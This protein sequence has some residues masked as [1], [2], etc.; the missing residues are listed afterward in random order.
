MPPLGHRAGAQKSPRKRGT[1]QRQHRFRSQ[2]CR[3]GAA[4]SRASDAAQWN[5]EAHSQRVRATRVPGHHGLHRAGASR[6]RPGGGPHRQ[7]HA[8]VGSAASAGEGHLLCLDCA[9]G[10]EPGPS[11]RVPRRPVSALHRNRRVEAELGGPRIAAPRP[12]AVQ[13]DTKR[14]RTDLEPCTVTGAASR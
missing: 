12:L 9:P 7:L 1:R 14:Q 4:P 2:R 8:S 3:S 13:A 6:G 11:A 10:A 5:S